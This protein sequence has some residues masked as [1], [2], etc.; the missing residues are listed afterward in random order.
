MKKTDGESKP[1][2]DRFIDK[3]REWGCN[4]SEARFEDTIKRVAPNKPDEKK[5]C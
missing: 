1:L 4:E 2:P 5:E 3:A